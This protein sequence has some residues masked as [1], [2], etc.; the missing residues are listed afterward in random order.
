MFIWSL[1]S[2]G[3]PYLSPMIPLRFSEMKDL[4]VRLP[5][6]LLKTRPK[7]IS[8]RNLV[9]QNEN[10]RSKDTRKDQTK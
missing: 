5:W 6:P 1:T 3:V 10:P 8:Q 9:R 2:F 7:E 4:F